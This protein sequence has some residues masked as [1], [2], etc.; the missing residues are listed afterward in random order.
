[1]KFNH[2]IWKSALE[3]L[4]R[5]RRFQDLV[6]ISFGTDDDVISSEE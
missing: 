2:L 4:T 1:M 3:A 5:K 6:T